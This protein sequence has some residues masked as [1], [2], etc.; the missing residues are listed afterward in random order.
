[1]SNAVNDTE[2]LVANSVYASAPMRSSSV[3]VITTVPMPL[4][5]AVEEFAW[6]PTMSMSWSNRRCPR[7]RLSSAPGGRFAPGDS[8]AASA[9]SNAARLALSK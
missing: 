7:V 1:M 9:A 4:R 8:P 6:S 3:S 2:V 5:A